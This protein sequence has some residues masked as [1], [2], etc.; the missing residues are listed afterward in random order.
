MSLGSP[1]YLPPARPTRVRWIIF[2]LACATS[3][4]LYLHRYSW[5]VIKPAIARENP[6]I[7]PTE[8]GWLD[9]AFQATYALGQVPGGMAGDIFGPRSILAGIILLWSLAGAGV[10]WTTGFWRLFAVR[11]VFGL[12]QAGAYPILSKV[13]R[14]WFPLSIRTSVQGIITA[15]GR[16]GAACSSMIIATLLMGILGLS[17]QTALIVVALPG[18]A[19]AIAFWLTV[20]NSPREHPWSNQ[21]EQELI[22]AGTTTAPPGQRATWLLDRASLVNVSMIFLYA[23]ASTFQDQL[24]VYWIP[25]FLMEGRGLA[26]TEM[27]L[28]TPLPLIGGA[29]GG[30]VGGVLNDVLLR[31][32]GNRRW[33]RSVVAFTGKLLAA[34]L[35]LVSVQM[36]DGR[37]AMVVLLAAKFFGDWSLPTQWGAITD[38]AGRASGTFFG[39]VNTVGALGG[40]VAGPILGYLKQC[41][42]WEGL[43]AGVA[44]MCLVAALT[45]LFIDCRRKLVAD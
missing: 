8:M 15:L 11:G 10:A 2:S 9:A 16:I 7:T 20:R 1:D 33:A 17:W 28:F 36:G 25:L 18:L 21:L 5:G 35:V 32:W 3:W 45:W 27:G 6:D 22:D 41:H 19:L 4:L 14:N 44:I 24:Y 43:F 29:V 39:L 13:T 23:F 40:F 38:M 37:L 26:A 42:G 12:T 34:I 30:I 31:A